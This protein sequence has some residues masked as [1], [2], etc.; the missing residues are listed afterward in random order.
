[1]VKQ[2]L[3]RLLYIDYLIR[4]KSAGSPKQL[5]IR[6]SISERSVYE[7]LHLMKELGA[8]IRYCRLRKTYYYNQKGRFN[9]KFNKTFP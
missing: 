8:P 1:M 5:A 9:F 6:L 4:I 7:L 3:D 2:Y